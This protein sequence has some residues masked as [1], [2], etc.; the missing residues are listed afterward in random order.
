MPSCRAMY[1]PAC[2]RFFRPM[3][4]SFRRA[5]SYHVPTVSRPIE[6]LG[7]TVSDGKEPASNV[8]RRE[9]LSYGMGAQPSRFWKRAREVEHGRVGRGGHGRDRRQDHYLTA[10]AAWGSG[11]GERAR[12]V[13][14]YR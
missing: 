11:R 7:A 5:T 8:H 3:L 14:A 4:P 1:W 12:A 9:Q 10:E 2:P 13:A 6:T